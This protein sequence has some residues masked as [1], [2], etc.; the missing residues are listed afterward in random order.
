LLEITLDRGARAEPFLMGFNL[1]GEQLSGHAWVAA[2]SRG[3][4][5]YQFTVRL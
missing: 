1:Q 2:D 3:Q 4:E 5:K